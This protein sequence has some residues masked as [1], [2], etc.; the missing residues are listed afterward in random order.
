MQANLCFELNITEIKIDCRFWVQAIDKTAPGVACSSS[1]TLGL[2]KKKRL[3][4]ACD[5][6]EPMAFGYGTVHAQPGFVKEMFPRHWCIISSNN[7]FSEPKFLSVRTNLTIWLVVC[8]KLTITTPMYIC[9]WPFFIPSNIWHKQQY[10][11]WA[12]EK[13]LQWIS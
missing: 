7:N 11:C 10:N 13:K 12:L 1:S 5:W 4:L 8:M 2:K 6:T 9:N 3:L